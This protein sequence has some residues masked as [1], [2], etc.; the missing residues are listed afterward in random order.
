MFIRNMKDLFSDEVVD[1]LNVTL[2]N[3]GGAGAEDDSDDDSSDEDDAEEDNDE[4]TPLSREDHEKIVAAL[5]KA[6]EQAKERRE[7]LRKHGID[8]RTG[9]FKKGKVTDE[10]KK[11]ET[12]DGPTEREL[13]VF[14]K[15]VTNALKDA[16]A[17]SPKLLSR[18]FSAE[19][20]LEEDEEYITNKL[21]ELKDEYPELFEDEDDEEELP[22]SRTKIGLT[23]KSPVKPKLNDTQKLLQAAGLL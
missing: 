23:K 16:G 17:K 7:L 10:V 9:E 6:N 22:K 13:R 15:E 14:S 5:A 4:Y 8:L 12:S 21:E 18:E 3:D 11:E 1:P 2:F 19:D 20:W